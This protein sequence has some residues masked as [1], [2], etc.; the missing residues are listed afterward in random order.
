MRAYVASDVISPML[1]PSGVSSMLEPMRAR[2]ASSCSRNGTSA[3]AT[4]TTCVGEEALRKFVDFKPDLILLDIMMPKIDG[5]EVCR[6]VREDGPE[7]PIIMLTAKGQESD[8]ASLTLR[9]SRRN[10]FG[11]KRAQ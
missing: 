3:V 6:I 7:V 10:R 8:I 2:F 5:H 1:G 9:R 4:L 11:P